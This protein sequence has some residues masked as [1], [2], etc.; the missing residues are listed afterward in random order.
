[1]VQKRCLVLSPLPDPARGVEVLVRPVAV[2]FV[3]D[4]EV[5]LELMALVA[6][7]D[8]LDGLLE[9]DGDDEAD[10]DGGD[11]DEEVF[12]GVGGFVGR[13]DVEHGCLLRRC[14]A[15]RIIGAHI[16]RRWLR[17]GPSGSATRCHVPENP[18]LA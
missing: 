1:M 4:A 7:V 14:V 18:A 11:V 17:G 12:P 16:E 13:V 2:E 6:M 8:E 5:F 10:D 15:K 9:T 3:V